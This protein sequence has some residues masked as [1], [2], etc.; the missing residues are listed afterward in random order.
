M[1]IVSELCG[2]NKRLDTDFLLFTPRGTPFLQFTLDR[3]MIQFFPF[4]FLV[5]T[6]HSCIT[7]LVFSNACLPF[8]F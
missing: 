1:E 4:V 3:S 2:E 6:Q 8:T 5:S 7:S